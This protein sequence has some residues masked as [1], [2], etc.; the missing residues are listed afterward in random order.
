MNNVLRRLNE[1]ESGHAVPLYTTLFGEPGAITLTASIVGGWD[2]VT[3]IGGA[4]LTVALAL[5][6]VGRHIKVDYGIFE[7][8]DD[9]SER[10]A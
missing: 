3:I 5:A 10:G 2:V 4:A 7:E 6:G 1:D 9:L 8:L